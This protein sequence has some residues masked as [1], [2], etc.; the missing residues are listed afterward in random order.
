MSPV[1]AVALAAAAGSGSRAQH[2]VLSGARVVEW[3]LDRGVLL[4][5][6]VALS[7]LV[8][9]ALYLLIGRIA[10]WVVRTSGSEHPEVRKRAD[11]LSSILR[12]FANVLVGAI[13]VLFVLEI[14]GVDVRPLLAGAGIVGVALGFG[15][16]SLVKDLLAGIFILAENQI[17]VGDTVSLAGVT[18]TVE[19]VTVRSTTLRDFE[20]RVHYVPNGEMKVVTN[21]TQGAARL[22]VDVPIPVDVDPAAALAAAEEAAHA[23]GADPSARSL[24]LEPPEVLGL[25]SLG[26]GQ[27]ILRV[28]VRA[29]RRDQSVARRLRLALVRGLAARGIQ[30]G[31]SPPSV[32]FAA[33]PEPF[34][35]AAS[36]TSAAPSEEPPGAG[37]TFLPGD[38]A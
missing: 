8:Q 25:E 23:F 33:A 32:A 36:G 15:A 7:W 22:L 4:L 20:G 37:P 10:R 16:Q 9:R 14:C 21:L 13:G 38:S 28:A 35:A 2:A 3:F 1:F 11:T 12:S 27:H 18:G 29:L 19:Q 30:A 6:V 24:L 31:Y 5:V 34:P 17:A 26:V